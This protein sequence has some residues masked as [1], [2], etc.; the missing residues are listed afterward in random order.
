MKSITLFLLSLAFAFSSLGCDDSEESTGN[1]IVT[2]WGEEYIEE[3][4]PSSEFKDNWSISYSKFIVNIESLNGA[5]TDMDGIWGIDLTKSG[6]HTIFNGQAKAT[7]VAPLSY[8]ITQTSN[9]SVNFNIESK[10]FELMK[11]ENYSVFVEGVARKDGSEIQFSWGFTSNTLYNEC[12]ATGLVGSDDSQPTQ[13][14]IHGDHLFY[15]SLVDSQAGLRFQVIANADT[16][17]DSIIT[18]QELEDFSGL[19]F[20]SLDNYDVPADSNIDNLWD[21]LSAQVTTIGHID[22]EGHCN[23][24][25]Q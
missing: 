19:E 2:V 18:K 13:L 9:E 16:N 7:S 4:I 11:S 10:D 20:T 24:I 5:D 23:I 1:L 3:S 25:I 17:S 14:T 21:Y 6:P 22:G 15:E 12:H 8:S